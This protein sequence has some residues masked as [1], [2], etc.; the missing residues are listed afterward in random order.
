MTAA[1]GTVRRARAAFLRLGLDVFRRTPAPLRRLAVDVMTPSYTVG[2]VCVLACGD[3]VLLLRQRHRNDWSLPG[4]L[5][6]R[7]ETP[8]TAVRRELHEELRLDVEVGLAVTT[9]VDPGPRRGDVVFRVEVDAPPAVRPRGEAM[10]AEWLRR[11]DLDAVD[12]AATLA[13][14]DQLALAGRPGATAGRLLR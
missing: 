13:V 8:E 2:A 12:D 14:L 10:Q 4:G 7:G 6:D 11:D 3:R 1:A 9:G 5:L